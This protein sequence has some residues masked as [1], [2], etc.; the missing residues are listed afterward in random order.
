M[1]GYNFLNFIPFSTIFS[2]LDERIGRVQILI[3]H[4]KQWS[5]PLKSSLP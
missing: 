4:Q 3:G 5:P 1:G 2:A